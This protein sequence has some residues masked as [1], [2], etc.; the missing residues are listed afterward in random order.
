MSRCDL[1]SRIHELKPY[2]ILNE[3]CCH[4]NAGHD[5]LAIF[6]QRMMPVGFVL[7]FVCF[8]ACL[9]LSCIIFVWLGIDILDY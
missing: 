1:H 8:C 7:V 4:G 2:L 3:S 6:K 9:D 5:V